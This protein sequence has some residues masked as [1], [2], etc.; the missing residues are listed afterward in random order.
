MRIRHV[1]RV[2]MEGDMGKGRLRR[3][4]WAPGERCGE[5]G[6]KEGSCSRLRD[7]VTE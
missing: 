4:L 3:Q 7:T 2:T 1:F 5:I 6:G